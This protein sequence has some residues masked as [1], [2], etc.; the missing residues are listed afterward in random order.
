MSEKS[1]LLRKISNY[2]LQSCRVRRGDDL[3]VGCS[4]G[5]DSTALLHILHRLS[6]A[7]DLH[8]TAVHLNH[9]L[10]GSESDADEKLVRDMCSRWGIPLIIRTLAAGELHGR[11]ESLEEAA[12]RVRLGFLREVRQEH[13]ADAVALGHHRDD[14]AETV[15]MALMRG[16]GPTGIAGIRPRR[17]PFIH[18]LLQI[19]KQKIMQYLDKNQLQYRIDASNLE[20]EFTRN[21]IRLQLLPQLREQF[22][23]AID[24]LLVQTAEIV[25]AEDRLVQKTVGDAFRRLATTRGFAPG[26]CERILEFNRQHFLS[27]PVAVQRRLLRLAFALI[28]G[29]KRNLTFEHVEE[30][31]NKIAG[32]EV[33]TRLHLPD[34]VSVRIHYRTFSL[35]P[36]CQEGKSRRVSPCLLPIPGKVMLRGG[37]SLRARLLTPQQT[38]W[39]RQALLKRRQRLLVTHTFI[40]YNKVDLPLVVRPRRSG[41]RMQ[42]LGMQGHK[43][44]KDI[45]VDEK[46]P[47]LVRDSIP[48]V[49]SG[50][51]IVWLSGL[52]V[53]E[54]YK[55]DADTCQAVHLYIRGEHVSAQRL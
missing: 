25:R 32:G 46:I 31:R 5:P 41:D 54:H 37:V 9:G 26:S 17:G 11:S 13:G 19:S 40:D 14:Q 27:E 36:R 3:I 8:L 35:L 2:L 12:R 45:L 29:D 23:P 18:P 47:W 43:K 1:N 38:K 55:V 16:A 7:L 48:L 52:R 51:R 53:S 30:T 39:V 6:G 49:V 28:K 34:G 4:G 44:V 33:G 24:S 20:A 21:R 50:S 15:I 42:P 22:N 10:R